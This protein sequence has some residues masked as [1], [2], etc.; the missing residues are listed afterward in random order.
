MVLAQALGQGLGFLFVL[1]AA[2]FAGVI[3]ALLTIT[4]MWGLNKLFEDRLGDTSYGDFDF[5][6]FEQ[7][8]LV[9]YLQQSAVATLA[10][11]AL[12]ILI[13]YTLHTFFIV[14]P[15]NAFVPW[16]MFLLHYGLVF[17]LLHVFFAAEP[18]KTALIAGVATFVFLLVYSVLL[19]A[20]MLR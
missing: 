4:A 12:A 7:P 14:S 13:V 18:R 6:D 15:R 20:N 11:T 3:V 16:I 17:W 9:R 19:P 10:P 5:D 1:F 8:Q 2:L